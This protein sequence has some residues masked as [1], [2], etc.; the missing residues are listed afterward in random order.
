M[1]PT[2]D[3]IAAAHQTAYQTGFTEMQD[4][5]GRGNFYRPDEPLPIGATRI[6]RLSPSSGLQNMTARAA[7]MKTLG[8]SGYNTPAQVAA[9][10]QKI[11]SGAIPTFGGK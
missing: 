6:N 5:A 3:A 10:N 8:S 4:A 11:S 7:Y 2:D 9:T 1:Q